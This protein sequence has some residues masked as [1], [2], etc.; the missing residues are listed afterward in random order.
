MKLFSFGTT[1][2]IIGKE[3]MALVAIGW[4]NIA[5]VY[6]YKVS[7]YIEFTFKTFVLVMIGYLSLYYGIDN[8]TDRTM[9]VLTTMLVIA[10]ITSSIE[11]V[12]NKF[13]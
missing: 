1:G 2:N 12:I 5:A 10:T 8:F 13:N 9:V 4:F 11:S 6:D 7:Q 3:N